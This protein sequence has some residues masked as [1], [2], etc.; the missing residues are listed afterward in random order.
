MKYRATIRYGV[1]VQR[2]HME[3]LEADSL[4]QA[5]RKLADAFPSEVR[6]SADLLELRRQAVTEPGA[7]A[8]G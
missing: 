4:E 2:Y 1:G 6:A 8:P 7:Q 5:M 3:D